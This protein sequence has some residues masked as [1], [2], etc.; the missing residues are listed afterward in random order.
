MAWRYWPTAV[1][2]V[3]GLALTSSLAWLLWRQAQQTD[4]TRFDTLTHFMQER[5]DD[6]IEKYE[7]G[8]A[9][10]REF[11]VQN[12]LPTQ[13]QWQQLL[14]RLK[15]TVN[16][17]GLVALGYVPRLTGEPLAPFSPSVLE[18]GASGF[19]L[20]SV[21]RPEL[22][23][24]PVPYLKTMPP[25]HPPHSAV[26]LNPLDLEPQFTN[27]RDRNAVSATRR[28][29]LSPPGAPAD[30]YGF[31]IIQPVYDAGLPVETP[32]PDEEETHRFNRLKEQRKKHCR[33]AV[34]GAIQMDQL[35]ESIL[36][37]TVLEIAF[38]IFDGPQPSASKR[39]NNQA[40]IPS[41]ED[42]GRRLDLTNRLSSWRMYGECW[43]IVFHPT[44][45]F[46]RTSPRRVAWIA[47]VA[48]I[49][50]TLC[51]SGL[52]WVQLRRRFTAE[53]H[54]R[55]MKEARDLV[56]SLSQ[57]RDR[58][59]RDLH[60]N[61]LPSFYVLGLGLRKT[62]KAITQN[63]TLAVDSCEQNQAALELAMGEL[64]RYL[65]ERHVKPPAALDLALA[66]RNL[67][68]AMNRQGQ[69]PVQFDLQPGL[70]SLPAAETTLQLLHIAREAIINAQRH[71]R[72]K[73]ILVSL[74]PRAGGLAM[75]IAD[76][77]RGFNIQELS[78]TGYG[79]NNMSTRARDL[80]AEYQLI[81]RP[82]RGTRLTV[83]LPIPPGAGGR[84]HPVAPIPGPA[85]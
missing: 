59:N 71:S 9:L 51:G 83:Y 28:M 82:G 17:P 47:L 2:L 67:A 40:A 73:S 75:I 16:C 50:T 14:E 20:T 34:L 68:E 48:G 61:V 77:G 25:V 85:T 49:A 36:A 57:E 5:L 58:I 76:D 37:K 41:P 44:T 80:G 84:L 27:A 60:D 1:V 29:P 42:R 65:G 43:T 12:E 78:S 39:L 11:F 38:E 35:L 30:L 79:L 23:Y 8:L 7:Q 3:A 15:L 13:S 26:Y 72:A 55:E 22:P 10:I 18:T 56:D 62:R 32:F 74:Q 4:Q 46:E 31:C 53:C 33:G 52:V 66:L 24:R 63:A 54:S 19:A 69:V 81:T 70:D 45:E 64:R 6:Q 21:L